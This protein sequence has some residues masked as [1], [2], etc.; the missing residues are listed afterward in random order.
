MLLLAGMPRGC[1]ASAHAWGE[2]MVVAIPE[3]GGMRFLKPSL[4]NGDPGNMLAGCYCQMLN[5]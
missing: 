1:I 5:N 4:S 2:I 3:G